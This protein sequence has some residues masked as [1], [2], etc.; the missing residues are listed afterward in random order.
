MFDLCLRSRRNGIVTRPRSH[1]MDPSEVEEVITL[2]ERALRGKE[3]GQF[4]ERGEIAGFA[5]HH[6]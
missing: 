6:G 2:T 1:R 5:R 4:V 3:R